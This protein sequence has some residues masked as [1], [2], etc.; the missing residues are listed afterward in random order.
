M[1]VPRP[2]PLPPVSGGAPPTP[3]RPPAPAPPTPFVPPCPVPEDPPEPV[4]PP[5]P[6]APPAACPIEPPKAPDDPPPAPTAVSRPVVGPPPE[7]LGDPDPS[8]VP[9]Q[10]PNI[11]TRTSEIEWPFHQSG[12][13]IF[14][15]TEGAAGLESLQV[16]G[17]RYFKRARSAEDAGERAAELI[18]VAQR[19]QRHAEDRRKR[20]PEIVE[21]SIARSARRANAG[22]HRQ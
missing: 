2:P 4:M 1:Q 6:G 17:G 5:T 13:F 16:F 15:R 3:V 20:Q 10:A 8:G 18:A 19:I 14:P 9:G 11:K 7:P 22:L 21:R 12:R